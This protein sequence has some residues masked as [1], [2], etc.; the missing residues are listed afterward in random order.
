VNL[1]PIAEAVAPIVDRWLSSAPGQPLVLTSDG[2]GGVEARIGLA[3]ASRISGAEAA[4]LLGITYR[5]FVRNSFFGLR[6]GADRKF[7]RL[8]VDNLKERLAA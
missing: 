4:R 2:A 5:T 3:D 6:R 7:S 1:S 8:Q